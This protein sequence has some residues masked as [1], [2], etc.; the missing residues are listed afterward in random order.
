MLPGFIFGQQQ[1]AHV[2]GVSVEIARRVLEAFCL[3]PD[4]RNPTFSN[5]SAFNAVNAYPLLKLDN[6]LYL[7]FQ[8][9]SLAETL[10]ESPF[11]WMAADKRYAATAL[12]NRGRFAEGLRS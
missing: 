5:L 7:L 1:V 9:Y 4:D 3:A 6:D 12:A 11:F 10:Y 2:A 8:H